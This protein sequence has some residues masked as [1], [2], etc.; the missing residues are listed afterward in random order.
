MLKF[1]SKMNRS[2]STGRVGS[3]IANKKYDVGMDGEVHQVQHGQPTTSITSDLRSRMYDKGFNIR[4]MPSV[5]RPETNQSQERPLTARLSSKKN[6]VGPP[7][8]QEQSAALN[9][10]PRNSSKKLGFLQSELKNIVQPMEAH[11]SLSQF[12]NIP[13]SQMNYNKQGHTEDDPYNH[14]FSHRASAQTMMNEGREMEPTFIKLK[15]PHRHQS[16]PRE[17]TDRHG[18]DSKT[19]SSRIGPAFRQTSTNSLSALNPLNN[20]LTSHLNSSI[21]V[22]QQPSKI[23]FKLRSSSGL[24]SLHP[25]ATSTNFFKVGQQVLQSSIAPNL[26]NDEFKHSKIVIDKIAGKHAINPRFFANKEAPL[27]HRALEPAKTGTSP[28]EN[29]DASNFQIQVQEAGPEKIRNRAN[30]VQEAYKRPPSNLDKYIELILKNVTNVDEFIYLVKNSED[31]PY[32]LR[33]MDYAVLQK[34]NPKEYYT[35][36]MKGLCHYYNGKPK[37]FISLAFW[38]KER[39]T[40]DKIKSLSFFVSFRKWKTLK[41][42]KRTVNKFKTANFAK[43]LEEKLFILHP[44]LS[45]ALLKHRMVCCD[46]EELRFIDTNKQVEVQKPNE[47]AS[48][49]E[50]KREAVAERIQELSKRARD[51]VRNGFKVCLDILRQKK[52]TGPSDEDMTKKSAGTAGTSRAKESAYEALGF[53]DNMTYERRSELRKEC[54]RF[55]RFSY[56]LDFLVLGSLSSVYNN[57]IKDLVGVL[58]DLNSDLTMR[59]IKGEQTFMQTTRNQEPLFYVRLDFYPDPIPSSKFYDEEIPKFALPPHGTSKPEDFNILS[60]VIVEPD[61]EAPLEGEEKPD[62]I[63]IE[64]RRAEFEDQNPVMKKIQNISQYWLSIN[65]SVE[66]I[67]QIII[68]CIA[69]GMNSLQVFERWSKHEE[70]TPF[71]NVLEEWDDMV[72]EDWDGPESNFLDPQDWIDINSYD[73]YGKIIQ[74]QLTVSFDQAEVFMRTYNTMLERFWENTQV[75]FEKFKSEKLYN[76]ADTIGNALVLLRIEKEFFER[77]LP[78]LADIG[79]LRIDCKDAREKIIPNPSQLTAAFQKLL[80]DMLRDRTTEIKAWLSVSIQ[81]VKNVALTID[82]FVKQSISLDRIN[83]EFP[84]YR[85]RLEIVD[86]LYN[87]IELNEIETKKEDRQMKNDAKRYQNDLYA[88]LMDAEDRKEKYL[89]KFRKELN[90]ESGLIPKLNSDVSDMTTAIMEPRYV[91]WEATG[92]EIID[93]LT[94]MHQRF[95]QL[96]EQSKKYNHYE[97]TLGLPISAFDEVRSLKEE[98]E[99]RLSMWKSLKEWKELTMEWTVSKF[100]EINPEVIRSKAENYQRVANKCSRKIPSNPILDE[101]KQLLYEFREAVPIITSLRNQKLTK[102]HIEEIKQL[103]QKPELDLEN[104]SLTLKHLLDMNIVEKSKEIVEI[105]TQATQEA[106]LSAQIKVIEDKW[107]VQEIITKQYKD[108]LLVIG[109]VDEVQDLLDQSLANINNIM[110]SRY[111]KR[112]RDR[113]TKLQKDLLLIQDT[114]DEWLTCQKNW[115]YL[116]NIFRA[117]DIKGALRAEAQQFETIDKFFKKQM[118]NAVRA[119]LV[120]KVMAYQEVLKKFKEANEALDRIQK[121]LEEYLEFKRQYFPRFYFLSNDELLEILANVQQNLRIFLLLTLNF[122]LTSRPQIRI[123]CNLIFENVSTTSLNSILAKIVATQSM[124]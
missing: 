54:S 70:L 103:L 95:K 57:S 76:P 113:A 114:L 117:S 96:E 118:A 13:L 32:D 122:F 22:G 109:E 62:E 91:S 5:K 16:A 108:D 66:S 59:V 86:L 40:Y 31:D 41:M 84:D 30:M 124:Q 97:D 4:T 21:T 38:L 50:K 82:D 7:V 9:S 60:H 15:E 25:S 90:G 100:K 8:Y 93:E 58:T 18:S 3:N 101:L 35:I 85:R 44:V 42:W 69:E 81:E 73:I 53:P 23:K 105:S 68:K 2:V 112:E 71:A 65:P 123:Q 34:E 56:L 75:D 17:L 45:K 72:S 19:R 27:S 48:T 49:Q 12:N 120:Q 28:H 37:E 64:R 39:E 63:E 29:P 24:K 43:S 98:I 14:I 79:M 26:T 20:L 52:S 47:F 6:R 61:F 107:K 1:Y 78:N 51:N 11:D 74:K 67:F 119:R 88:A 92:D 121:Q 33:V 80:P 106:N 102:D 55:I 94:K 99:L 104:E 115:M 83:R 10:P 110:G 77:E 36:S 46:I 89:E 87:V 111:L 116:E